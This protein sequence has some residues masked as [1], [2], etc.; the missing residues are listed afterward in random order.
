MFDIQRD[1]S[2][3]TTENNELKLQLQA[4]EQQAQLHDGK[5]SLQIFRANNKNCHLNF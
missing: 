5:S 2:G 4:M 3:L 1:T